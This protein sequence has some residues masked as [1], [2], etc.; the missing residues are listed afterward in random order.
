MKWSIV[1]VLS[2]M[3]AGCGPKATPVTPA[4]LS[5]EE[6]GRL[7]ESLRGTWRSTHIKIGDGEKKS[8][9]SFQFGFGPGGVLETLIYTSLGN[10]GNKWTYSLDGKNLKTT[11]QFGT[12]RA[13][14]VTPTS[15]ELFSY[16]TSTVYYLTRR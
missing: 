14:A 9:D 13:D 1:V 5:A 11:S 16:D 6:Q 4:P 7:A 12:L 10:V 3:L 15:L 2:A 8:E